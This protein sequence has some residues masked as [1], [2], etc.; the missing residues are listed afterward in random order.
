M[1]GAR[2]TLLYPT[3][4]PQGPNCLASVCPYVDLY[5]LQKDICG[6]VVWWPHTALLNHN[7]MAC[8]ALLKQIWQLAAHKLHV[9]V[10]KLNEVAA[11]TVGLDPKEAYNILNW[12]KDHPTSLQLDELLKELTI[13]WTK[14]ES[15]ATA[16]SGTVTPFQYMMPDIQVPVKSLPDVPD[17]CFVSK[18]IMQVA[19]PS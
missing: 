3:L 8:Y 11:N 13:M 9:L 4:N 14:K 6:F 12:L 19:F 18:S 7:H 15:V 17:L 5:W 1:L 10:F 16:R 2:P